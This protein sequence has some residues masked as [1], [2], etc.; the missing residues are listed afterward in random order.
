LD[1]TGSV[2]LLSD[3]ED[4]KLE[5]LVIWYCQFSMAPILDQQ[6]GLK[7]LMIYEP[8]VPLDNAIW[9]LEKLEVLHLH[10][11][12]SA[13]LFVDDFFNNVYKL[14]N[15]KRLEVSS[16]SNEHAGVNILNCLQFGVFSQLE[17]LR[18]AFQ[19]ARVTD[20]Q[21]LKRI[22]PN[23]KELEIESGSS[24][25]MN[26]L[27]ENVEKL[28]SIVFHHQHHEWKLS[29]KG[30]S[31]PNV[32]LIYN[33]DVIDCETVEQLTKMFPNVET[34]DVFLPA[35]F[36]LLE[37]IRTILQEMKK[38]KKLYLNQ[39]LDGVALDTNAVLQGI[40]DSGS[41]LEEMCLKYPLEHAAN[42]TEMAGYEIQERGNYRLFKKIN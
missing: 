35:K 24:E 39:S 33:G 21:N 38:L 8:R 1:I 28:E 5:K 12:S 20:I 26:E 14:K 6:K 41:N 36:D 19:N 17:K 16:P 27:L 25:V 10:D 13:P 34:L 7:S 18:G 40:L 42:L 31:C 9:R 11:S 3:L 2:D 29:E 30:F 4:L 32:K 37:S 23:L 15:L 22:A